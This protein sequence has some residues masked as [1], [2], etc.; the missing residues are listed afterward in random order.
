MKLLAAF[1]ILTLT[2]L[3]CS[4]SHKKHSAAVSQEL[5]ELKT[6]FDSLKAVNLKAI[7]NQIATFL[8][9]QTGDSEE[10]MNLYVE[11]F[12]NSKIINI[13]R[14]GKDGPGKVG[15][16]MHAT[17]SLN[18]QLFMCSDG[19]AIH[20]W[21]FTP[22]VSNFVECKNEEELQKLFANLSE[23]GKIMMPLNNYGFS[24]KFGFVEDRYGVSWQ[25][26]LE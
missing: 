19:P 21:G 26:N 16:I 10:A 18:G 15:S 8:T 9:F 12:D 23:N 17:F 22:A 1:L 13:K 4:H 7:N 5:K 20:E 14:W 3:S 24:Q 11:L 6:Q 25:L 2:V